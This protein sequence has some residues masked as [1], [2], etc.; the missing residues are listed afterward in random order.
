M[1]PKR[2]ET[3]K[4]LLQRATIALDSM[5]QEVQ[6]AR[7]MLATDEIINPRT[8]RSYKSEA[9]FMFTTLAIL[10]KELRG[11]EETLI[12]NAVR[13][14]LEQLGFNIVDQYENKCL[15]DGAYTNA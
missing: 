11:G 4:Q 15:K 2:G 9:Q 7:R 13:E 12:L 14:T 10:E 3:Y 8:N 5:Q 6:Q 1:N